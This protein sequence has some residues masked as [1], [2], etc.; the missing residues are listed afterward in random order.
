MKLNVKA[1]ALTGG[2]VW[3]AS[4]LLLTVVSGLTNSPGAGEYAGY[5]GLFLKGVTS[6]Y[7]GYSIS[8][9]GAVIGTIYGFVDGVISVAIVTTIYNLLCGCG[10]EA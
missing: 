3:G 4:I 1:A 7:P 5:A 8:A 2:I 6:L 9:T 10:K